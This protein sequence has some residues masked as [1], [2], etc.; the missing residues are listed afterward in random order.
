MGLV[1]AMTFAVA[2][3]LFAASGTAAAAPPSRIGNA[4]I[5]PACSTRSTTGF[6]T[7]LAGGG[8]AAVVD[9]QRPGGR[10]YLRLTTRGPADRATVFAQRIGGTRLADVGDLAFDTFVERP[11]F[12]NDQAA[13]GISIPIR[14]N[15]VR[16]GFA[17][18]TWEPRNSG[19]RVAPY[20]WQRWTP[21]TAGGGWSVSGA[22]GLPGMPNRFGLRG[23]TA[24]FAQVKAAF[25]DAVVNAVG[26]SQG[27]G[28][29]GLVGGVDQLRVNG[30][31]FDFENVGQSADL[32]VSVWAPQAAPGATVTAKITVTNAGRS[33]ARD[34]STALAVSGGGQVSTRDGVVFGQL[35]A[36]RTATLGVGQSVTYAVRLTVDRV[37]R[38]PLVLLASTRSSVPDPRPGNNTAR[39]TVLA[40]PGPVVLPAPQPGPFPG[41][42]AP[43]PAA[44]VRSPRRSPDPVPAPSRPPS[45][46][47]SPGRS[48]RP[49]P[50]RSPDPVRARSPPPSQRRSPGSSPALG[51]A[52]SP[53]PSRTRLPPPHPHPPPR[54]HQHRRTGRRTGPS[55]RASRRTGRSRTC[56]SRSRRR[57]CTRPGTRWPRARGQPGTRGSGAC[58]SG[59]AARG[60]ADTVIDPGAVAQPPHPGQPHGH[61]HRSA[62]RSAESCR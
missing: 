55:T 20:Q 54:R 3:A 22:V 24:T 19:V 60:S 44:R 49:S 39:T 13:P 28:A 42:P 45:P 4:D 7:E 15:R 36:F 21:S 57:R 46:H 50:P 62:L 17:T 16:G 11:A 59:P 33:P 52:G 6:C 38:G 30:T 18:L 5:A 48:P 56:A 1:V 53:R 32:G 25:P 40:W 31:T 34:V 47:R 58:S 37:P 9:D 23:F 29:A 43:F 61:R 41:Q 26:V 35:T 8:N 51:R 10:G 12:G 14:S 2:G 27:S